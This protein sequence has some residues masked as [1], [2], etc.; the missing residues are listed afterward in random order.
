MANL[1]LIDNKKGTKNLNEQE[2]HPEGEEIDV[3]GFDRENYIV[4]IELKD[5]AA[6]E[7]VIPQAMKYAVWVETHP[8]A[9]DSR[10]L[11]QKISPKILLFDW[12]KG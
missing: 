9:I 5:E 10:W 7:S 6:D 3:V 4:V 2:V 8:D 11:E 1:I 12:E